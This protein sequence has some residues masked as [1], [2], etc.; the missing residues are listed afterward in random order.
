ME[1][2]KPNGQNVVGLNGPIYSPPANA[3][4]EFKREKK[5]AKAKELVSNIPKETWL[6]LM[7]WLLLWYLSSHAG[8]GLV[9]FLASVFYFVFTNM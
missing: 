4:T 1:R 7:L 2:N 8:F 5:L 9:F 3:S 6:K